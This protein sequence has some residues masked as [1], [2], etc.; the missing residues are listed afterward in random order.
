MDQRYI[1][2]VRAFKV[3]ARNLDH[4]EDSITPG[5]RKELCRLIDQL[6]ERLDLFLSADAEDKGA[7]VGE[8]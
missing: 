6:Q 5:Q 8:E 1:D 4:L 2:T 7:W 3:I